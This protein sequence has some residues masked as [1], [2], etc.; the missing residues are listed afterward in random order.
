MSAWTPPKAVIVTGGTGFIGTY[1]CRM[2]AERG[3]NVVAA[4]IEPFS[5][6]SLFLLGENASRIKFAMADVCDPAAMER[7]FQEHPVQALVHTP[8]FGGHENS[9]ANPGKT[10]AI[11]VGGTVNALEGARKA[12]ASKVVIVSSNAAYHRKEYSPFDEKHP[13]TSIYEGNPNAHYGTSKMV[14]EQI[15]LAY[16]TY[17]DMDVVAARVTAVYGFRMRGSLYIKPMIEGALRGEKVELPTGAAVERD[18]TYVEDSAAGI[19]AML[20]AD[21]RAM[22]QRVYNLSRGELV[23][24]GRIAE[25]VRKHLPKADIV[26]S[27]NLTAV[28]AANVKQRAPLT[29][30]IAKRVFG[31]EAKLSIEDGVKEYIDKFSKFLASQGLT[32]AR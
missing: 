30:E 31:F 12:G 13:I 7:L 22:E 6:E 21:T 10:Y 18:Y 2:L 1:V 23:T 20:N 8:G 25:L 5:P 19:V 28:E 14:S 29:S 27:D 26:I 24:A 9:V 4:G 3:Q 15:S 11:N 17:H 16:R 32:P